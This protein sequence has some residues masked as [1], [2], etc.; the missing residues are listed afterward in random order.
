MKITL[1][2]QQEQME[3]WK[4][5][6]LHDQKIAKTLWDS[7]HY[8]ACLFFCHLSLEK[9]LK[10]HVVSHKKEFPS[11]THDLVRLLSKTHFN[12]PEK[13]MKDLE[14]FTTFNLES[15][16]PESN[17]YEICTE[18]FSEK[19]FHKFNA[20]FSLLCPQSTP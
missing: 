14:V 16:Y 15:R 11:R 18:E 1:T 13:Y 3:Y 10:Y 5:G 6:A 2:Q 7:E 12:L 19:Y 9:C 20:L 8:D 17:F 4:K